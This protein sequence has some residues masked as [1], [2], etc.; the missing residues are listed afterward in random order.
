M[1]ESGQNLGVFHRLAKTRGFIGA[2]ES[3][4]LLLQRR[5]L[6]RRDEIERCLRRQFAPAQPRHAAHHP[7]I[8]K[9]GGFA[10][11]TLGMRPQTCGRAIRSTGC[12]RFSKREQRRR[13]KATTPPSQRTGKLVKWSMR[14]P[15][16]RAAG[17]D[18]AAQSTGEPRQK[19]GGCCWPRPV[20]KAALV[21]DVVVDDPLAPERCGRVHVELHRATSRY[22]SAQLPA[23]VGS[24]LIQ[25]E[26]GK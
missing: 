5:F 15:R 17:R 8:P 10:R 20:A 23:G 19:N 26:P 13:A 16:R 22:A 4:D 14:A 3:G 9:R 7:V 12:R 2:R 25:P 1:K 24:K 18:A 21:A 11:G 6:N